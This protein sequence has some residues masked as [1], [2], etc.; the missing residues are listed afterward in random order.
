MKKVDRKC[1][2]NH[3]KK[4][5]RRETFPDIVHRMPKH[6]L[7]LLMTKTQV[8][9]AKVKIESCSF[10]LCTSIR[11]YSPTV[12][13]LRTDSYTFSRYVPPWSSNVAN[14]SLRAV[15][16]RLY[17]KKNGIP[18]SPIGVL[19]MIQQYR[20]THFQPSRLHA[21]FF[22]Y[23]IGVLLRLVMNIYVVNASQTSTLCT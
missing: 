8:A 9:A 12:Y 3:S 5:G 4:L 22:R 10:L 16:C 21:E 13:L 23:A 11:L 6:E 19:H 20:Q 15:L 14:N 17:R 2:G 18:S 7:R 1:S